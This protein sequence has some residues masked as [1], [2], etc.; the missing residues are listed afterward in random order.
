[1]KPAPAIPPSDPAPRS[2]LTRFPLHR[3]AM[4]MVRG[5]VSMSG[6]L[7]GPAEVQLPDTVIGVD[8]GLVTVRFGFSGGETPALNHVWVEGG[9]RSGEG[10]G[11]RLRWAEQIHLDEQLVGS[12]P[13]SDELLSKIIEQ[14]HDVAIEVRAEPEGQ[15]D[16]ALG[17]GVR[18][19]I[20][21]GAALLIRGR[22][23]GQPDL[24]RLDEPLVIG[25]DGGGL[26]LAPDRLV[27]RL[28]RMAGI[29]LVRATLHPDGEVVLEADAH[30]A[31]ERALRMP[32]ERA[33]QRLSEMVRASPKARSFLK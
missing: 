15:L 10:L 11:T 29:K 22:T 20:A 19:Q 31:I 14:L 26:E 33:G 28:S 7:E 1:M 4:R 8:S 23:V 13:G 16:L 21:P 12:H 27:G 30:R 18:I 3:W 9:V 6:R 32:L 5:Q 2:A 17:G 24:L 25:F